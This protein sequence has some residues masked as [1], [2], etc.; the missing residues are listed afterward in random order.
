MR[1][2]ALNSGATPKDFMEALGKAQ[3]Q[4]L[5]LSPFQMSHFQEL[6]IPRH[7]PLWEIFNPSVYSKWFNSLRGKI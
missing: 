1:G 6:N 7:R 4:G 3:E 2:Q 5:K